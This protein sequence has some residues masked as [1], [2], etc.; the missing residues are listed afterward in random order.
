VATDLSPSK[1]DLCGRGT[2]TVGDLLDGLVLDEQGLA[3]HVVAESRVLGD[4]DALLSHPLDE[5]GLEETGVALDLVGG[6]G[7]T[8]LVDESL[9]VLLGVVGNT[10]ST[11]LLLVQLGHS[12]PC[13][14]DRDGVEHL[15]V[16]VLAEGE[17]VLVDILLLIESNGEVDQVQ[18]EVVET[19]LSKTVVEGR[20]D[21]V[22]P[23][24]RVP[25][26]GCDEDIL[27]LNALAEGLL[28][29]LGNL[30]LVPV[31]LGKINVLVASLESLVDGG[32]NLTGLSLP[33]SEPQLAGTFV[34][35]RSS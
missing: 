19:E 33:C 8:G 6:R 14:N 22:G 5:F 1:D 21:I 9:E 17:E 13:V 27:A 7:D 24:L 23:V 29:S 31:D 18:I 34:R 26:L 2:D 16:T 3:N 25:E 4:V 20:G 15:D 30:L 32:L 10:N 28:E 11:S 35:T 12:P